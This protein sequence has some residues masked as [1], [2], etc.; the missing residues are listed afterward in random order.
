MDSLSQM[1]LGATTAALVAPAGYRRRALL[2]GAVLGTLPDL[3]V[4]IDYGD[5]VSNFTRHRGFSHS[6]IVLPF[7][8]LALWG[9]WLALWHPA[10]EAKGRW[11]AAFQLALVTHPLLDAFTVYGTQLFWPL[12][13]PPVMIG[14]LFIIDPL[15]TLPLLFGVIVAWRLRERARAQFWLSLGLMVSS[16]YIGWSL[17]AQHHIERAMRADLAAR[18]VPDA[19]LLVVPAP[20]TTLLWRI[21][22]VR[23]DGD[24]YEGWYSFIAPRPLTTLEHYP[25]FAPLLAPLADTTAV[26]R[27]RWFTHGFLAAEE[28]DARI[29]AKD[30]RMG[31][32]G[33]YIFRFALGRRASPKIVPLNPVEQLPWPS[34]GRADLERL[35]KLLL[36]GGPESGTATLAPAPSA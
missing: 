18:G 2:L 28:R 26:Q 21:L 10:R 9:L 14:S 31:V 11:L 16:G 1:V 30:L 23:A 20:F 34:R 27:L 3:D 35:W 19:K 15:Y 6:L 4:L 13:S 22:V 8:A 7:A 36:E 25:G 5:P 24:Y 17:I 33:G 32:E 12:A 29:V